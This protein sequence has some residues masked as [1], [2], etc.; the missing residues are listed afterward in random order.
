MKENENRKR[1][2]LEGSRLISDAIKSGFLPESIFFS[3]IDD[4]KSLKLPE[5][6]INLYKIPYKLISKWSDVVTSSGLI[7][8]FKQFNI[9]QF[10]LSFFLYKK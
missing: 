5:D 2:M 3:R 6:K 9:N 4:I 7:G 1:I 10:L 8:E